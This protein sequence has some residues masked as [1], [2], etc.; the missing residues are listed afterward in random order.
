M[1]AQANRHLLLPQIPI[2]PGMTLEDH[3]AYVVSTA[4]FP[5]FAAYWQ[6]RGYIQLPALET[7][8]FPAQH[9]GFIQPDLPNQPMVATS[10]SHDPESPINRFIKLYGGH[11]IDVDGVIVPGN[12]Q[13][14]AYQ[15]DTS[16]TSIEAVQRE[17]AGQGIQFMTP[18][19]THRDGQSGGVIR[20]IFCACRVPWGPFIELVERTQLP[21]AVTEGNSVRQGFDADQIDKLYQYYHTWSMRI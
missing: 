19:L 4:D 8:Q 14:I 16:V 6:A 18:L 15:I 1:T 7:I 12:V 10:V 2:L 11:R 3:I 17:L 5:E 9:I 13:H 20:Q 21:I